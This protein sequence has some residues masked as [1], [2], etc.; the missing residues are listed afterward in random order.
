MDMF[1]NDAFKTAKLSLNGLALRQQVISRN[2]SNVDTPGY[3]AEDIS[4]EQTVR[5]AI[6]KGES[7]AM[8]TTNVLHMQA[9]EPLTGFVS[10][11]RTGGTDRADGNNVDID[12]ELT[13]MT[14]TSVR[15]Q[16]ISQLISKKFSLL[17]TIVASR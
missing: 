5:Q 15:Y 17:K 11:Q 4:F 10:Q 13:D 12:T 9:D 16:A 1:S 14:E 7:A 3:K 2:I 6:Q 8:T